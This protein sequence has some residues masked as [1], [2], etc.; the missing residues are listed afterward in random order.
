MIEL[1]RAISGQCFPVDNGEEV[2]EAMAEGMRAH[3]I[4]VHVGEAS[5][6]NRNSRHRSINVGLDFAP[7]ATE[8][9]MWPETQVPGQMNWEERSL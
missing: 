9:G 1:N 3:K 5:R 7:L 6:R 2:G 4:Q 8:T